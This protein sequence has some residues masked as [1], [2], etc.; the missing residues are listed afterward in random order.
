ML[1]SVQYTYMNLIIKSFIRGFHFTLIFIITTTLHS[2]L[3]QNS[4]LSSRPPSTKGSV[5]VQ[6]GGL[7]EAP[8]ED[9]PSRGE[10][11]FIF[12][13]SNQVDEKVIVYCPQQ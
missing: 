10:G 1:S 9:Q 11:D 7:E 13:R 3:I 8:R 2:K 5:P 12:V 6:L 4:S